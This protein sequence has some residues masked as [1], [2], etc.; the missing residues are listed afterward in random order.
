MLSVVMTYTI[1]HQ[2]EN[3]LSQLVRKM[4][5]TTV[6]HTATA[7]RIKSETITGAPFLKHQTTQ[8]FFIL[9][10]PLFNKFFLVTL[11]KT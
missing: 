6:I 10:I 9:L 2:S 8:F 5:C 4:I 3:S 1:S 7:L 11:N